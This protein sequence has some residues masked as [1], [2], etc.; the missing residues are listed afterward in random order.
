MVVRGATVIDGLGTDPSVRDVAYGDD[1]LL[2]AGGGDATL[3]LG[4]LTLLP[5]LIDA[6]THVAPLNAVRSGEETVAE[7]AARIFAT[8]RAALDAGFTTLRDCGGVD[9]GVVRAV[10]RGL[11]PGPRVIPAGPILC[12]TGGHGHLL[13]P[14]AGPARAAEAAIPGLA[15][16]SI[17]CDGP[18][19][20]RRGARLA[21]QR[22]AKFLKMCVTGGVISHSDALTDTQFT[23]AELRAA[24]E[25]AA[26]R[27]TYVTVH[28]HNNQGVR[29]AM[30]A[31]VRGVEHGTMI[32]AALAAEMAAAGMYVVPTLA[33]TEMLRDHGR[34]QGFEDAIVA[35]LGTVGADM[36]AAAK[37]AYDA[38]MPVGSGSDLTGE[39]GAERRGMEIGLKARTL[40]AAVAIESATSVNARIL[41]IAG[42]AGAI[43]PGRHADLVAVD[44]DPLAD[45][46]LLGD[47]SRV[48][49]V[50]R[51]GAIV[52]DTRAA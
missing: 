16:M 49:L 11:V 10:D 35:R 51:E 36:A 15:D 12:Q 2:T 14:F 30:E 19:A 18:D 22:G 39:P 33:I 38:G 23:V 32:D 29:N 47:P 43:E 50:V 5:G 20:V 1:G 42:E 52:K 40:G 31:G 6:H 45:P 21:F 24:V 34:E 17:V 48:K 46:D 7:I 13:P 8:L 28:A 9:G 3:D 25:E 37:I 26:A 27:G 41:G 44:G 4:G